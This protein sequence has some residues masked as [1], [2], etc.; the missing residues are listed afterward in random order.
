M[1][2][3][4]MVPLVTDVSSLPAGAEA[5]RALCFDQA[6]VFIEDAIQVGGACSECL[7]L[8]LSLDRSCGDWVVGALLVPALLAV[9]GPRP[10]LLD[11]VVNVTVMTGPLG[12]SP[13]VLPKE[14][15]AGRSFLESQ[16]HLPH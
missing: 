11:R 6:V 12:A 3:C 5:R 14:T 10:R 4:H 16:N 15:G 1:G 9:L 8:G 7:G 13:R 2:A